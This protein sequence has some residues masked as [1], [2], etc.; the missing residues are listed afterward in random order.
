MTFRPIILGILNLTPDSFSDGG[1]FLQP[2]C[3]LAQ[4]RALQSGG[5]THLDVGA[6][7]TRPGSTP[8][9]EDGE[10]ARLQ[11]VLDLLHTHL[12]DLPLSLD[13]RHASVAAR[14]L[15]YRPAVLN[16]VTGFRDPAMLAVAKES[17]TLLLAMRSRMA[18][19]TF[20][21]PPYDGPG[22]TTAERA[23]QELRD[24]RDRLLGAGIAPE[25]VLLDPGIGFG[26]TWT[27]DRAIWEALPDL[28]ALLNWPAERLCIAISRK[29]FTAWM[30]GDP[31]LP[32]KE[33]DH[34]TRQ[35]HARAQ[36]LGYGGFRTHALP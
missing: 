23:V 4:A 20:V 22:E 13:T 17:D 5:A 2:E 33:R 34:I 32:P 36:A 11:P 28:P 12:P 9:T 16:D 3:A 10:W 29:R 26:T 1:E 6:E 18:A 7:S 25:R 15:A 19:D 27:E 8:I 24:V 31:T 21:M 30:A 14:A 35:L